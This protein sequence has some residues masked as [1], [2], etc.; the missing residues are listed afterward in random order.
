MTGLR[1]GEILAIKRQDLNLDSGQLITRASDNKGNRD[2]ALPLH[3]VV[4]NHLQ[5]VVSDHGSLFRWPHDER[6]LWTE[7]GRIQR[8]VGIKLSCDGRHQHTP[9]CEVYGFHDFRRAFATAN[10]PRMKPEV[11]QVLMRHKSYQTTLTSYIDPTSQVIEAVEEMP[12]LEVLRGMWSGAVPKQ[13]SPRTRQL[14]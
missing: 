4:V 8:A 12:V 3:P 5:R 1:I 10:A 14:W 2:E 9:A 13:N 6:T 7:F 11:L